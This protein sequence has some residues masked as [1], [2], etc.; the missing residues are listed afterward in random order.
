MAINS[1]IKPPSKNPWYPPLKDFPKIVQFQCT[2]ILLSKVSELL[3]V[4]LKTSVH[5]LEA[6]K[7][8]CKKNRKGTSSCYTIK[9]FKVCTQINASEKE[10]MYDCIIHHPQVV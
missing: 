8:N 6:D 2:R 1:N 4:K 5:I 3:D 7:K 10:S 9:I